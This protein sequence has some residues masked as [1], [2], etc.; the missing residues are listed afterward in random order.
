MI[1]TPE[2]TLLEEAKTRFP[3]GTHFVSLFGATDYVKRTPVTNGKLG[4][5]TYFVEN[6]EVR[7]VGYASTRLIYTPTLGWAGII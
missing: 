4:E 2:E 5:A 1:L 6:G 3:V 7:V